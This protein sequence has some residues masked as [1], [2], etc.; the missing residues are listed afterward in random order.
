[1][2]SCRPGDEGYLSNAERFHSDTAGEQ[3]QERVEAAEK[4]KAAHNFRRENARRR[5]ENRW[6]ATDKLQHM[7]EERIQKIR[8]DPSIVAYRGPRKN[9]SNV[10]YDITNLQYKQDTTGEAQQ[11]HDNMVRYRAQQRTRA[12]VVLGDSRVPYNILT[13][14][15]RNL[16][17]KAK[18][19]VR[20]SCLDDPELLVAAKH[21]GQMQVDKRRMLQAE[22]KLDGGDLDR[23]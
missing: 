13:G 16:P 4:R 14:G 5:E 23:Q 2:T 6:E 8:E 9:N 11:Y 3:F 12:L 18:E 17:P 21:G 20:P 22:M 19:V 15:E 1:L 10:A 7:E